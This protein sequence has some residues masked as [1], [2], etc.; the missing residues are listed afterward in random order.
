VFF[1]VA[2]CAQERTFFNLPKQGIHLHS[3]DVFDFKF[4]DGWIFM[5]KM[6]TS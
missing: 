3:K 2:I 6:K 1:R 5:M 4:F